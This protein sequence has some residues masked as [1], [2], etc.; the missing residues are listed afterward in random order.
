MFAIALGVAA[1]APSSSA[2]VLRA[3]S[4]A[5]PVRKVVNLLQAMQ[6]KVTEEGEKEEK[7]YEKFMCYCKTGGSDLAASIDAAKTK[8]GELGSD[9]KA[10][11]SELTKTKADLKQAQAERASGKKAMAEA[12]ALREKEAGIFAKFKADSDANIAALSRATASISAGMGSV[13]D[14]FVGGFLQTNSA[15]VLRKLVASVH[16]M[17]DDDRQALTAFL[18]G[19]SQYAPQSGQ[20][21]GILKTIHDEMSAALADATS[22]EDDA[23]KGYKE[24]MAARL[25]EKAA[26]TAAIETKLTKSGELAVSLAEMKNDAGDTADALEHDEKFLA[27]LDTSCKTKTGEWQARS[28]MR[29]GELAAL[30]DTIKILND[31]DALELFKKTLPSASASFMQV[32]VTAAALRSGALAEIQ[33]GMQKASP[34]DRVGLDLISMAIHGKKIGFEKIISMIDELVTDLKKEQVDDDNKMEYC[35]EQL[36]VSD[37]KK[38]GL[39]RKISDLNT[40]IATGEESIATLA[41]EI[42]AL[43]NG[44]AQLDKSVAEATGNRKAEHEEYEDLIAANSAAKEVLN[45]AK[46]RL[47]QFYNPKL[48][49]ATPVAPPALAQ[50][51]ANPGPPPE[52]WGAYSKQSQS[53]GGVMQMVNLLIADLDK[54]MTEGE[55]DEKNA[56]ADYETLMNDSAEKRTA[57][58]KSLSDKEGAKADT[59]AAVEGHDDDKTSATKELGATMEY[60]HSLH[61]ECDWLVKYYEVRKSAR[62]DELDSLGNAK[63]VLSGANFS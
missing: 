18:A 9:I 56:Q 10:T 57:D 22:T 8:I 51:K 54:E 33:Q 26:L 40:A 31:D 23:I 52:S 48:A 60:I 44:I 59:E 5:N 34:Q 4:S 41:D 43:K 37:D 15:N 13:G 47:N 30:A 27:E 29:T 28:K 62:A 14:H 21:V 19:S 32:K 61:T 24:L 58:S 45:L 6:K 53:N 16:Q 42:A 63:A 7:L 2:A 17:D 1:W 50:A 35:S 25:K 3:Q 11:D 49:K 36:D 38:K 39:E 55:A 20:I 46:N 12:T